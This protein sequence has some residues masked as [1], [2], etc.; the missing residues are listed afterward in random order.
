MDWFGKVKGKAE[1]K[2]RPHRIYFI[3]SKVSRYITM[4]YVPRKGD[5]IS[6]RINNRMEIF[7][8]RWVCFDTETETITVGL[9]DP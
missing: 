9:D 6:I 8:V 5:Y 7:Y 2:N 4:D 1:S 3:G